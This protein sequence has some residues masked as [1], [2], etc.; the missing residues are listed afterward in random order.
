MSYL[1]R[2]D[3]GVYRFLGQRSCL[4]KALGTA[5]NNPAQ[6]NHSR[7][8][9]IQAPGLQE[10]RYPAYDGVGN[11]LRREDG[12]AG[13][14][15]TE[16]FAYDDLDR[17]TNADVTGSTV[18]DYTQSYTYTTDG[19]LTQKAQ[20]ADPAWQYGARVTGCP[21]GTLTKPHAL[22]Q[23]FGS[24]P[25]SYSYDCNGNL[26]TRVES[27]TTYAQTWDTE[28]R[29]VNVTSNGGN[30][31]TFTYD[32]D[33][34]RVK[35]TQ[36]SQ[37]ILYVGAHY[38]YDLSTLQVT[39]YYYFGGQRIAMR[40]GNTLTYLHADHLGSTAVASDSA[41]AALTDSRVYY[42]PFGGTRSGGSGLPTEYRY[43]GQRRE[44]SIGLYDYGA[45]Y[46]E[47]RIGRFQSPDP[48]VPSP[49]DLQGLN[50]YAY[51]NNNPLK[52]IDPSGHD[53][54]CAGEDASRCG[55]QMPP[56][57]M[58][59]SC[60]ADGTK[61]SLDP[62]LEGTIA[63]Y[64]KLFGISNDLLYTTLLTELMD[65]QQPL[66][67]P[68]DA[69]N[70]GNA[71]AA[72]YGQNV[73]WAG[74]GIGE[75][76][77]SALHGN[78]SPGLGYNNIHSRTVWNTQD[79]FANKYGDTAMA[80]QVAPDKSL[81]STIMTLATTGGN[82]RYAAAHLRV[83]TDAR[84]NTQEARSA[85]SVADQAIIY[86]A[87]RAGMSSYGGVESFRAATAIGPYGATYLRYFHS[88]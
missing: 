34:K 52:Y 2:G 67:G 17:L 45:R 48:L 70:L 69:F 56:M 16:S 61:C 33:G 4:G 82:V 20:P 73:G 78:N 63:Y 44:P 11:L 53:A 25:G 46:Y 23:A 88:R 80:G 30:P 15:Q 27:G 40:Q 42:Y 51:S 57:K 28:N 74:L 62:D 87:Y 41:G 3:R 6:R 65:D 24:L 14:P 32:G 35:K 76:I 77:E 86:G 81:P 21:A 54:Q 71:M 8:A 22:S 49:G 75:L 47:P 84:T 18:G 13:S 36:G 19:N 58:E 79:Y 10:L 66:Q 64:A 68:F 26:T 7:L 38:E 50:R 31:V 43:T 60:T 37:T 39:K 5:D 29:L 72:Y 12:Q 55:A 85:L 1:V 9:R 59:A 83:L